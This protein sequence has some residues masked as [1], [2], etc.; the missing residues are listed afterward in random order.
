MANEVL[1]LDEMA[2]Y[3]RLPKT[4]A[5]KLLHDVRITGR[6]IGKHWRVARLAV[7]SFLTSP[8]P[9]QQTRRKPKTAADQPEE[10]A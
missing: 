10:Q 1:T 9:D 7:A 2:E 4:T 5:V 8:H 6:M 3:L